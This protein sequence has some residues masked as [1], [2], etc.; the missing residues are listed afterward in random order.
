MSKIMRQLEAEGRA[1]RAKKAEP[2]K[3]PESAPAEVDAG[4]FYFIDEEDRPCQ[5][6]IQMS[7]TCFAC[8]RFRLTPSP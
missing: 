2:V 8:G 1:A 3:P 6:G 5:H 4:P 7:S